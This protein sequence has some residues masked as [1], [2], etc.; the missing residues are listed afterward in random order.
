MN[1]DDDWEQWGARDPY[2][3]VLTNPKFRR[4]VLDA[5]AKNEFFL[6]GQTHVHWVLAICRER[7]DPSFAPQAVLDFGCGVGRL[8]IAF[9][10]TG[11]RVVGVDVSESMLAEARRN[12]AERGTADVEL[13]RSDD[14]LSQVDGS[15]DL[16]H[17]AIVLQHIGVERGRHLFRKL[18]ERIRPGGIG[19]LHVTFALSIHRASYGQPA[20]EPPPPA[21]GWSQLAR[22][23]LRRLLGGG[24]P[25]RQ[26]P[27]TP[28]EGADPMMQMN[29]YNLSELLFVLHAC[30]VSGVHT[31]ITDHGGAL[32]AFLFFRRP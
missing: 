20:A 4:D 12:C 24:Q 6:S 1:T 32:G 10:Q 26:P 16:V 31:H 13:R 18:V 15:F 8:A 22:A 28:A 17:S 7:I 21:P 19:A 2:F 29:Y 14:E 9:A 23:Q 5:E 3:G 30:G 27:E 25:R 11:S